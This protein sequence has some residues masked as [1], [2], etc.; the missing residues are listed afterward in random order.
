M[1]KSRVTDYLLQ[2]MKQHQISAAWAAKAAKIDVDKL[3]EDYKEPLLSDEF[4]ELCIILN[5]R[6]EDVMAALNSK[7][8]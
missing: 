4:L 8:E 3:T 5:I 6:P 2:Y 7:N 1:E